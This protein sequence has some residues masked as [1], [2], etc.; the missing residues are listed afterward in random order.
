MHDTEFQIVYLT[1]EL[2][3]FLAQIRQESSSTRQNQF[4]PM[5]APLSS[6]LKFLFGQKFSFSIP[7][8]RD[9]SEGLRATADRDQ[10]VLGIPQKGLWMKVLTFPN[11]SKFGSGF[12]ICF[13]HHPVAT[14]TAKA[15]HELYDLHA[16]THIHAHPG[17]QSMSSQLTCLLG[18]QHF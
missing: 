3:H 1:Y 5:D 17:A 2:R 12:V 15:Q 9:T 10:T 18:H 14:I 6:I 13:A 11:G 4:F 8:P 16:L 7:Q